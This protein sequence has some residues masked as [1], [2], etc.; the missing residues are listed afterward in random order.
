MDE[1]GT[2]EARI[3]PPW[4]ER[5]GVGMLVAFAR[6]VEQS[7]M[8][9]LGFFRSLRLRGNV[10]D[11]ALYG[12]GI[13]AIT[14]LVQLL[15][16]TMVVPLPFY[17]F[18]K[19]GGISLPEVATL[20][21]VSWLN[22][23]FAPLVWAATFLILAGLIHF[24]LALLGAAKHPF[25]TTFRIMCYAATPLLLMLV[26]FCGEPIGKVWMVALLVIGIRECH[27]TTTGYALV[28]VLAPMVLLFGCCGILVSVPFLI[29]IL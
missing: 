9:P 1:A 24:G 25:E 12:I 6:T 3:G 20:A 27:E 26:P 10:L 13:V 7:A 23:I 21:A 16:S 15:W 19:V 18:G 8:G 14:A 2:E 22:L 17:L 11:A 5:D 4:E 28:A 29:G